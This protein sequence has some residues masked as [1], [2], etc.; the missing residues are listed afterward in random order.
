[1]DSMF[2]IA[3]ASANFILYFM[4]F[5][6]IVSFAIIAERWLTLRKLGAHSKELE[7]KFRDVIETQS[8]EKVATLTQYDSSVEGRALKYGLNHINKS[9]S[10]EGLDE[11]FSSFKTMEKPK[12]EG[13]LYILGTI[14]SNAPYIGL[15]GTVMGIMKAFNDL[16]NAPGQGNE[17]VMSGIAHALVST[18]VGLALAIP[19]VIAFNFFQKKVSLILNNIDASK[20]L[21]ML[22]SKT[23]KGG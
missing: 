6:S 12:L 8:P 1:M 2:K 9:A 13:N 19:A 14:A 10:A 20:D 7:K 5:L 22:Y 16:G 4:G 15:L 18:A 17:V 11:M 23:K 21:C 3:E